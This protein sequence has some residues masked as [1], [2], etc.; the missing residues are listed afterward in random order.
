MG[1]PRI[2]SQHGRTYA[3]ITRMKK[4]ILL[5][6]LTYVATMLLAGCSGGGGDEGTV[7]NLPPAKQD[8]NAP[9]AR[10]NAGAA[11]AA[12]PQ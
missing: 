10:D 8:L 3:N 11:G 9:A 4:A 6:A 12:T 5:L 7:S 1:E 2:A